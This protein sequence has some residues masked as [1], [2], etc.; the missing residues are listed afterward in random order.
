MWKLS[1]PTLLE[2]SRTYMVMLFEQKRLHLAGCHPAFDLKQHEIGTG[3][4]HGDSR[5]RPQGVVEPADISDQ[6]NSRFVVSGVGGWKL[7]QKILR[8]GVDVP[9][10]E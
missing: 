7:G 2:Q 9:R 4:I 5:Y 8:Q 10:Q 3:G 1:M 6:P